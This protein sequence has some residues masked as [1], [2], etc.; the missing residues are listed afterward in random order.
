MIKPKRS[1]Q[2][3]CSLIRDKRGTRL[4]HDL[5]ALNYRDAVPVMAHLAKHHP[6]DTRTD[7]WSRDLRPTFERARV[8]TAA[9]SARILPVSV[10]VSE[11]DHAALTRIGGGS[12]SN[13]LARLIASIGEP[14]SLRAQIA[15]R[16]HDNNTTQRVYYLSASAKQLLA[17]HGGGGHGAITFAVRDLIRSH[18][19]N[20]RKLKNKSEQS[21]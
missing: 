4:H 2:W 11:S 12:A 13:G 21:S 5:S 14:M 3:P 17:H 10:R 15:S 8:R 18:V 16:Q 19:R 1:L 9:A 7:P 20:T 6:N